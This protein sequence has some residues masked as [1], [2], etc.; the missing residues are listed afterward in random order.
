MLVF[1]R[2]AS[3]NGAIA[4]LDEF[5]TYHTTNAALKPWIYRPKNANILLT[6][7]LKD[8]TT[9]APLQP[10]NPMPQVAQK[11]LNEY[12]ATLQPGSTDL[13]NWLK[14]WT[15]VTTRKKAVWKYLSASHIQTIL[16]SSFFLLGSY[17]KVV[18]LLYSKKKNF[19]EAKNGDAFD[20]EHLFNTIV[21]CS[22]H[23][24][25]A[26]GLNDKDIAAKKLETAWRQVTNTENHTGLANVLIDTYVKQQSLPN[27]PMLKGLT[28]TEIKLPKL[29]ETEDQGKLNSY[30]YVNKHNYLIART[31][32]EFSD[33]VDPKV[34]NFIAEYQTISQK[35]NENDPYDTYKASMTKLLVEKQPQ[36][37]DPE[38]SA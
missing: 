11:A 10:R 36:S 5:F 18:G 7:D 15:S 16:V 29:P 22:L 9:G 12:I 35:L 34:T 17:S 23:R 4:A 25:A 19:L 24:N 31:I 20:V 33:T 2:F 27:Q 1:K 13:L 6:M 30:L 26:K 38:K 14:N 21:M 32:E 28:E 3:S 8:P 37:E